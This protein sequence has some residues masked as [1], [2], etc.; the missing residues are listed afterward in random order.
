MTLD[1]IFESF[2]KADSDELAKRPTDEIQV[3]AEEEGEAWAS[4]RKAVQQA[5]TKRDHKE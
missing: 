5:A 4:F 1:P 2:W 3:S